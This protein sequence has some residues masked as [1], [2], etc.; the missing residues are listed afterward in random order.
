MNPTREEYSSKFLYVGG[1]PTRGN[2]RKI[3]VRVESSP[4]ASARQKG[5]LADRA[6]SRGTWTRM[7]FAT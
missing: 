3:G 4:V 5:E 6:S 2:A 7:P 1:I